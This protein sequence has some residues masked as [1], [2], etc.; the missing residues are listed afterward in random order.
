MDT[1]KYKS[2]YEDCPNRTKRICKE[3]NYLKFNK[4]Q[5]NKKS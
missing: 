4:V 2:A 5:E 1:N 3:A